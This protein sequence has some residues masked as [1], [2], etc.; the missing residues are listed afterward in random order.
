MLMGVISVSEFGGKGKDFHWVHV[1]VRKT[2]SPP[3]QEHKGPNWLHF[4]PTWCWKSI[5]GACLSQVRLIVSRARVSGEEEPLWPSIPASAE[6]RCPY[7][8]SG[9]QDPFSPTGA[10][11]VLTHLNTEDTENGRALLT[12]CGHGKLGGLRTQPCSPCSHSLFGLLMLSL[13]LI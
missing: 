6:Q 9:D 7:P 2:G 5:Q 13:S 4:L 8:R 12:T 1:C 10:H 3:T 11:L